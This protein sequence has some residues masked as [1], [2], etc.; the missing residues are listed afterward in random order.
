MPLQ[1]PMKTRSPTTV[2][3]CASQPP[4]SKCHSCDT[5]CGCLEGLSEGRKSTINASQADRTGVCTLSASFL[6]DAPHQL[7]V[8]RRT[9]PARSISAPRFHRS[10]PS[11]S[12]LRLWLP[13]IPC[14]GVGATPE[15]RPSTS[16]SRAPFARSYVT[17]R[18]IIHERHRR[19][20]GAWSVSIR[21]MQE[22]QSPQL[23]DR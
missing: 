15:Q 8:G 22:S 6:R 13:E 5:A 11:L 4:A 18:A 1:E 23:A 14:A 20:S 2:G 12:R 7:L 17:V 9:S 10:L 3:V 21:S 16:L 19:W